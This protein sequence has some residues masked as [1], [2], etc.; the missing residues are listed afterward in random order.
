MWEVGG[1]GFDDAEIRRLRST[2]YLT[3]T[4]SFENE[5]LCLEYLNVDTRYP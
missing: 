3:T 4:G 5:K 1:R 2:T